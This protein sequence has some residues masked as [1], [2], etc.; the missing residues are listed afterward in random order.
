MSRLQSETIVW[1]DRHSVIHLEAP[2]R[3]HWKD[4]E[5]QGG[6]S[7]RWGETEDDEPNLCSICFPPLLELLVTWL[8][9]GALDVVQ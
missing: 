3:P 6:R 9:P 8:N 4:V 5:I 7:M 2:P 1:V